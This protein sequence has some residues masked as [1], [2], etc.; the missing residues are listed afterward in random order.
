MI[1]F[2]NKYTDNAKKVHETMQCLDKGNH[3]VVLE[4]YG[5]LPDGISTP[6]EYY[7]SKENH[8]E[9]LMEG[10]SCGS[11][12]IPEYW[13]ICLNGAV[14]GIYHMGYEQATIYFSEWKP[15]HEDAEEANGFMMGDEVGTAESAEKQIVQR[16]EW[17]MENGWI[18]KVDFYNKY[19]LKYVS[20][21]RDASGTVESKVF[22][23]DRNQEVIVEYPGNDVVTLLENG[24]VKA[25]F[26][27]HKEFIEY[28]MSEVTVGEK[29]VLFVQDEKTLEVLNEKSTEEQTWDSVWFCDENLLNKYRNQGGK[30]GVRFYAIPEHYPENKAKG[31]ALILTASD[32]IERIEELT[33]ELTDV[34]FHIAAHTQMSSK[35][36]KLAEQE[37]VKLYPCVSLETLNVLWDKCDFYLD[38][39]HRYEIHDAV[40]VA[41]QRNLLIMGFENTLHHREL[42]VKGCIYPTQEYK[43]ME[44]VIKYV[45]KSPELMKKL[46]AV[47][48]RRKKAIWKE[49]LESVEKSEG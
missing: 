6:Y 30:N 25:F 12:V 20:E 18:Y 22:Y 33:K 44:L 48:Q 11:L 40:N 7:V 49:I 3:F 28:Y 29:Q 21:F 14:G 31:E 19:G 17:R 24:T 37:N 26:N 41:H 35:L 9:H 43:K 45:M 2:F 36:Y 1:I 10:L 4:D 15:G 8:E 39:N 47:Q 13:E 32:Q 46:L 27:S 38:I 23:S 16:V 34:T 42:L 5:F